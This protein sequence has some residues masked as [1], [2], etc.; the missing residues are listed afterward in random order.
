MRDLLN[1]RGAAI[2]VL[3]WGV[4]LVVGVNWRRA[5]LPEGGLSVVVALLLLGSWLVL[6]ERPDR[7]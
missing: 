3:A 7:D 5:D 4:A 1:S 6:R 2:I